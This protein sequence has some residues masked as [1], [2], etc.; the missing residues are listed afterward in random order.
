MKL[1]SIN[2]K[3][4]GK[5]GSKVYYVNHGVQIE[6]EYTSQISNPN[7][8]A[9]VSQRS[10]FKLASQISAIFEP[11]IAIPRKGMQSPRNQFTKLNMGF[12]YGSDEDAQVTLDA[13]QLT[14]GGVVLPPVALQRGQNT[15]FSM[16]LADSVESTISRIIYSVFKVTADANVQLVDSIVVNDPGGN[17]TF[18]FTMRFSASVQFQTFY[19]YAYGM[20]DR[21]N[22]AKA[23]FSNYQAIMGI[24]LV[25][26]IAQRTLD[27]NNFALTR[28]QCSILY[29]GQNSNIVP[30]Q[31]KVLINVYKVGNGSVV[32]SE[33]GNQIDMSGVHYAEVGIG[34][35]IQLQAIPETTSGEIWEFDGW[36]NNGEQSKFS[37]SNPYTFTITEQREIVA[38]FFPRGLE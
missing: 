10:R 23:V 32:V 8:P 38:K 21:T 34:S 20:R 29:G 9:Q 26:L 25:R 30:A 17:R 11:V 27:P 36:Y 5:S 12:F 3:G 24:D 15:E 19:V 1:D 31:N 28:T 4:S 13:L 35:T 14:K 33:N 18:P 22:K 6:R 7:T 2:G 37:A 16:S